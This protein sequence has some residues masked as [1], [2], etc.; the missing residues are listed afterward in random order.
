MTL[1]WRKIT[2]EDL[3]SSAATA[4]FPLLETSVHIFKLDTNLSMDDLKYMDRL[5]CPVERQKAQSFRLVRDR[6]HYIARHGILRL[7]LGRYASIS[8][9]EVK[10]IA[11]RKGKP[12]LTQKKAPG[13]LF[14]NLSH[15]NATALFAVTRIPLVGIDVEFRRP[16]TRIDPIAQRYFHPDEYRML[17]RLAIRQRYRFYYTL[18]TCKEACLKA[19]GEGLSGLEKVAVM[20]LDDIR[21]VLFRTGRTIRMRSRWFL[22]RIDPYPDYAGALAI[23]CT[24]PNLSFFEIKRR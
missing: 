9:L 4:G 16:D 22:R 3:F 13:R 5:L 23:R 7:I 20:P 21:F 10:F 14:F 8:P 24:E 1:L 2:I 15:S 12:F 17:N 19:T 6:R 18:W 11:G